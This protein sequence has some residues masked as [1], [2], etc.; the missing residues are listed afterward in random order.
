VGPDAPRLVVM[1]HSFSAAQDA[2]RQERGIS[3]DNVFFNMSGWSTA[4]Q[5]HLEATIRLINATPKQ[6]AT[7]SFTLCDS[8]GAAVNSPF[9]LDVLGASDCVVTS[10]MDAVVCYRI[11]DSSHRGR[12]A[13][14][15]Y[16]VKISAGGVVAAHTPSIEVYSDAG[17]PRFAPD[18]DDGYD[19][20]EQHYLTRLA[21]EAVVDGRVVGPGCVGP[22]ATGY[23]ARQQQL[24]RFVMHRL[25]EEQQGFTGR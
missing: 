16:C 6:S 10:E 19:V 17:T 9:G 21:G 24:V 23:A 3:E 12:G 15:L 4:P 25:H 18:E 8:N 5:H 13:A 2:Y 7:L 14:T 20:P 1:G 22:G 11:L